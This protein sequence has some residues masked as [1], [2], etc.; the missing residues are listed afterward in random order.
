MLTAQ[1][2]VRISYRVHEAPFASSHEVF[3]CCGQVLSARFVISSL[4]FSLHEMVSSSLRS[5]SGGLALL[6]T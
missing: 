6:C 5:D 1:T 3:G 4:G 2:R